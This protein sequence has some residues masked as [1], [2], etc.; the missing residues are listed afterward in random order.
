LA[1]A[2]HAA[3]APRRKPVAI[4]LAVVA[5]LAV[6]GLA[7]ALTGGNDGPLGPLVPGTGEPDRVTPEFA[8]REGKAQ[9]VA[10]VAAQ[11]AKQLDA[12]AQRVS[13]ET[14]T[15][16][17]D[18]YTA[19][20]LDPDNWTNGT[21]DSAFEVFDEASGQEA[22]SGLDALTAGASAGETFDDIQPGPSVIHSR[23]L[24]DAKGQAASVVARVTFTA[25]AANTDGTITL[26][27]SDG[28]FFLRPVDGEWKVV[29][30][31]VR[32]ADKLNQPAPSASVSGSATPSG[33]AS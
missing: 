12:E 7:F 23:V 13:K 29:A 10:T 9:A 31:D 3:Q 20:F 15:V 11:S 6:G 18:L 8:F 17:D 16:I 32:R 28:E 27:V 14:T 5:V 2:Q 21:Y 30:F 33:A 24:M 22:R 1:E 19:A 25:R 4:V 26:L